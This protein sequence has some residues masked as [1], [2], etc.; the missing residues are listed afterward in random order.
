MNG[1]ETVVLALKIEND[2][3]DDSFAINVPRRIANQCERITSNTL[4]KGELE[5][6][7][8]SI[9]NA[10]HILTLAVSFIDQYKQLSQARSN[11]LDAFA[12]YIFETKMKKLTDIELY[13][14]YEVLM[15]L[16]YNPNNSTA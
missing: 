13:L 10:L 16:Q 7:T 5:K 12:K 15:Y 14:M 8:G 11:I 4:I 9:E 3:I 6:I 1:E 2:K